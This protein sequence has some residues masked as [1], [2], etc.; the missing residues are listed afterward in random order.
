MNVTEI[1]QLFGVLYFML[2]L[3]FL[4]NKKYYLS[5]LKDLTKSTPFILFSA[6]IAF[7]IGFVMVINFNTYTLSKE[8]LVAI[9][10]LLSLIKGAFILLFPK[11][12]KKLTKIFINKKYFDSIGFSIFI[13]GLILIYVG[14]LS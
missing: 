13:L 3:A 11:C 7:V 1:I 9:L 14:F 10:G 2:G 5:A 4:F 12:N 8:G 6:I